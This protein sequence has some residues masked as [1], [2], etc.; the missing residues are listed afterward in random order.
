M[1]AAQA[2]SASGVKGPDAHAFHEAKLHSIG[3]RS[4]APVYCLWLP[5]AQNVSRTP[6]ASGRLAY[7]RHSLSA[8]SIACPSV[9]RTT[10]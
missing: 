10:A 2:A 7:P 5:P 6:H 4:G 3:R 1:R 9:G 8:M